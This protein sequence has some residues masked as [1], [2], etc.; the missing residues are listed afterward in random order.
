MMSWMHRF[1]DILYLVPKYSETLVMSAGVLQLCRL[2]LLS[3]GV[4]GWTVMSA[5]ILESCLLEC[6]DDQ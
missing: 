6:W 4:L 2:G 5:S 3:T 1:N